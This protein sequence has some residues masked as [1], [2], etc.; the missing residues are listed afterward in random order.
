VSIQGGYILPNINSRYDQLRFGI[1]ANYGLSDTATQFGLG[2]EAI[3][4]Y[5]YDLD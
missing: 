5:L 1:L 4:T 2:F 3:V